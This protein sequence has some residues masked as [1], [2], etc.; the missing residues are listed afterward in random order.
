MKTDRKRTPVFLKGILQSDAF[1]GMLCALAAAY[2]RFV[3]ATSRWTIVNE[4]APQHFWDES[5]PFIL[6]F[7]HGRL[8]MMPYCWRTKVPMNM[9][10]SQHRD[11]AIISG[12][13]AHFGLKSVRGSAGD[14][15]KGG[16]KLAKGGVAA[17]RA[18][19]RLAASGEAVGITPDGPRGPRMRASDGVAA[20]ARVCGLPVIPAA[21]ATSGR[22][23]L[24]TWDKFNVALPFSR[25]V[26]VWGNP[27]TVSGK[28]RGDEVELGRQQ[29]EDELNRVTREADRLMGVPAI[30]PAPA[31]QRE[32][33]LVEAGTP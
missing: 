13:I 4:E 20:L 18:M 24:G 3:H 7:W 29:I 14:T 9:L 30:E 8:L 5:K 6:A 12:T 26:I 11:G 17:L 28:A 22:R 21:Y 15:R 23:V 19:A 33:S 32:P 31:P 25:G 16:D 2:I 10:I 1:R 27:I